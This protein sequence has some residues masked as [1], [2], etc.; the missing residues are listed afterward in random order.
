MSQIQDLPKVYSK[1]DILDLLNRDD[2]MVSRAILA[3]YDNQEWDEKQAEMTQHLNGIGF[4]SVDAGF[5]SSIAKQ[6][7]SGRRLSKK[8]IEACRKMIR[9]YCGQLTDI[10]NER[11]RWRTTSSPGSESSLGPG[12]RPNQVS[13]V[14]AKST[15]N[16]PT[17]RGFSEGT[18]SDRGP[19]WEWEE[20]SGDGCSED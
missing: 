12:V 3:I 9:K 7:K 17:D 20:S 13:P 10:A 15:G 4:N 8:Q 1:K 18:A 5:G 19:D 14:Q 11:S 2:R 16:S 6:L